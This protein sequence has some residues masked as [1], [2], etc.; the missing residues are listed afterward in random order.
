MEKEFFDVFP[1]LKV[2]DQLKE[3]LDMVKVTRV[4]CNPDK[5]RLW[6]YIASDRW[7]HKKFI[8]A[9]E[10]QIRKQCFP[11]IEIQIK[12]IEKFHL[13]RQYTPDNFLE[14]YHSSM[15]LELKNY[16]MLEY[17]LFKR[18]EISFPTEDEMEL[19]LPDSVISREK[20][21]IL[22]EYL[23]KVFCERCG[24]NLKINLQCV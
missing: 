16:N 18:A 23:Q 21:E 10:D 15:E 22:V 8:L 24:M 14:V 20:S 6:V 11:G 19:K 12:V 7:I 2:K 17:N 4:S 1:N 5:T 9:L 13:S 3:W